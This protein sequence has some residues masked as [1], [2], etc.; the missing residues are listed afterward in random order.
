MNSF[1]ATVIYVP[2]DA[3][4]VLDFYVKAFGFEIKHYDEQMDFGELE[5][6]PTTIAVAS[7]ACG[8]FMVGSDYHAHADGFPKNIEIAFYTDN[9]RRS[10]DIAIAGGCEALCEPKET[11]WGQTVAY[12]RSIEGSLI[13]LVSQPTE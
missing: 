1:A 7:H 11:P 2:K 9:V 6:G 4:S 5:T 3:K 8:E 10:Y 13:G 12:V